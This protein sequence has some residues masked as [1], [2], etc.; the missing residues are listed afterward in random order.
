MYNPKLIQSGLAGVVGFLPP[1]DPNTP[2]ISGSLITS[3]TGIYVNNVYA[4]CTL[5]FLFLAAPDFTPSKWPAWVSGSNYTLH[6]LVSYY[7]GGAYQLFSAVAAITGSVVDPVTAGA[8][9]WL[10]VSTAAWQNYVQQIYN[11]ACSN[12]IAAVVQK[13]KL[14]H[15]GK[16]ILE[17]QQLYR[18]LGQFNNLIVPMGNFVGFEIMPASAEGLL[19][20][21]EKIGIQC[22]QAQSEMN[23]YLYHT[24]R[25]APLQIFHVPINAANTF[26]WEA[27]VDTNGDPCIIGYMG[28]RGPVEV[29]TNGAF[30]WGYHQGDLEGQAVS[31]DWDC[32][33]IPCKCDN[34]NLN[35]YNKW[36]RTTRIRNI[37]VPGYCFDGSNNL[38]IT[39]EVAYNTNSNWGLNM[40][41]SVRCDLT[42]TIT[43]NKFLWGQ[44]LSKSLAYEVLKVLATS[45]RI[46]PGEGSI[47]N[48]AMAELD[49]A[50]PGAF[51]NDYLAEIDCVNMDLSG[52]NSACMPVDASKNIEWGPGI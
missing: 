37:S 33:S 25:V 27:L 11:Q 5:D 12:M 45:T 4:L 14:L 29:D 10:N 20:F 17:R 8:G 28:L 19:I 40:S 49:T 36:S 46:G 22:S 39:N 7:T 9:V 1:N 6:Q 23:Y 24:S 31:K 42:K 38:I 32:A 30:W 35:M 52:F 15:M 21:I 13:K 50:I 41:I 47:K 44:S 18:G 48:L 3:S 16:A 2:A 43:D 51:I 34:A 26:D